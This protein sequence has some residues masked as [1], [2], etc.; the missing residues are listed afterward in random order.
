MLRLGPIEKDLAAGEPDPER[1][2]RPDRGLYLG[3]EGAVPRARLHG[4]HELPD[5][6]RFNDR[7]VVQHP[8]VCRVLVQGPAETQVGSASIAEVPAGRDDVGSIAEIS[9]QAGGIP[10]RRRIV[11]DDDLMLRVC[12]GEQGLNATHRVVEALV[13]D[14]HGDDERA[15]SI[16]GRRRLE[17]MALGAGA[18][19]QRGDG[20][21]TML[22]M[23]SAETAPERR[24]LRPEGAGR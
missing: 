13:V 4:I 16:R 19:C 1:R 10:G 3:T 18:G 11:D 5:T 24:A 22:P 21:D 23:I 9:G 2:F 8:Y 12:R 15:G 6:G 7:V 14:H 17:G 20:T